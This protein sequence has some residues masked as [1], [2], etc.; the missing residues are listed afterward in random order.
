MLTTSEQQQILVEWNQTETEYPQDKCIHQLFE[1]QVEKMP[2]AIAV[3]FEDQQLT[4][5]QLNEKANQLAHY[6]QEIGVKPE[7]L[8]GICIERSLEMIVGLLG[9]LKAGGAYVPLDPNS[10]HERMEYLFAD[11][12]FSL[13]ITKKRASLNFPKSYPLII[14]ID[15]CS[16]VLQ[17]QSKSNCQS[18]VTARNLG[19]VIYTS[20]STGQPKG[21]LVEHRSVANF[22]YFRNNEIFKP[23]ELKAGTVTASI[24]F[25][26]SVAQI[27]SPL[28]I[29]GKIVIIPEIGQLFKW[30]EQER[31][32]CLTIVPSLLEQLLQSSS[33]P[34][35]I[36]VIGLG[37]EAVT[38]TLLKE[39]VQ[40]PNVKKIINLYGPTE[41][42]IGSCS[43][44]IYEQINHSV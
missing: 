29:G 41:A 34:D 32:T 8:V 13:L 42:T 2:D 37:G 39:L 5:Q 17:H 25:D 33:L 3:V 28:I 19:Y 30:I 23:D 43:S 24:Y 15:E 16:D 9:I 12:Q 4:Y 26:A 22:L 40:H 10:P 35:S 11:A 7:V 31:I 18:G 20:G 38:E 27:F 21:V 44:I 6:L 36:Q 1:E 14:D